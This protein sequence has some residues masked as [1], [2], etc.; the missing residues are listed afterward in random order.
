M[1]GEHSGAETDG[2]AS[3]EMHYFFLFEGKP[4]W[5]ENA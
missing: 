4:I 1:V 2:K 5:M 3:K